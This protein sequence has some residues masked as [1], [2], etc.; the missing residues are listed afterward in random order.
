MTDGKI[1]SLV[2]NGEEYEYVTVRA[3]E[4]GDTFISNEGTIITATSNIFKGG[5]SRTIVSHKTNQYTFGGVVFEEIGD[6]RIPNT[7]EWFLKDGM[8]FN[9]TPSDAAFSYTILRPVTIKGQLAG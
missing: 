2:I 5:G 6:T 3:P 9:R 7:G 1:E 8:I 4:V